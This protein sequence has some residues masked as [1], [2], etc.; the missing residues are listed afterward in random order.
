MKYLKLNKRPRKWSERME[1][2][3]YLDTSKT[4]LWTE[5]YDSGRDATFWHLKM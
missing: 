2:N 4:S 3:A 1:F 5:K